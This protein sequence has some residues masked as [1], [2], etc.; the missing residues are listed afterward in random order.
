RQIKYAENSV[1][2]QVYKIEKRK[3]IIIRHIGTARNEQQKADLLSL[4]EDFIKKL[5]QQLI[6]FEDK[7]AGNILHVDQTEFIGVYYSFLHELISK[8]MITIGFDKLK[9]TLLLDLV[10]IRMMEPASKLRSIELLEEYF[11]I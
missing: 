6:L 11:G 3:R 9:N 5:S 1:S 7:Q 2:I 10:I 8:L 4:A